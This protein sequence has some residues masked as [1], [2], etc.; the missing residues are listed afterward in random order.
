MVM[1][2]GIVSI[3]GVVDAW[4]NRIAAPAAAK[5]GLI[6]L[7][8]NYVH[9]SW[10]PATEVCIG[11][12]NFTDLGRKH[13][14]YLFGGRTPVS[15]YFCTSFGAGTGI[16]AASTA[17]TGL[18]E[19]V[20]LGVSATKAIDSITFT[21]DYVAEIQFTIGADEANGYLLTELGLFAGNGVLLARK[22]GYNLNKHAGFAPTLVWRITF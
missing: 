3:S 18:E 17:D 9:P 16:T 10:M 13:L 8:Q 4:G 7:P 21:H 20:N 12:N 14:A 6:E 2:E 11:G 15:D 1:P 22:T 19:P 5:A